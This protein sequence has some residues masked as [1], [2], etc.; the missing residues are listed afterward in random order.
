MISGIRQTVTYISAVLESVVIAGSLER[1][2]Y[3][4][5]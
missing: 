1:E 5:M 2:L 4:S 3:K